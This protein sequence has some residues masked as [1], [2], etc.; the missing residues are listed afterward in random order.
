VFNLAIVTLGDDEV[1]RHTDESPGED[2][3]KL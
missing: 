2:A 1:H 3:K